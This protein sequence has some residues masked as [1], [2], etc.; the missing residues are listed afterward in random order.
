MPRYKHR[1]NMSGFMPQRNPGQWG[2]IFRAGYHGF[3]QK[4]ETPYVPGD[5]ILSQGKGLG[6]VHSSCARI[7]DLI[8]KG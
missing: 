8:D 1:R 5:L 2:Q 3:C 4:C 6:A 7:S